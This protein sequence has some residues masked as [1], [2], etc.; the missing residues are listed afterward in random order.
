MLRNAFNVEAGGGAGEYRGG[1]GT[2]REY[3]V[4][5]ESG[6]TLLASLGRSVHA[7]WGVDGGHAGTRQLLRNRAGG[8]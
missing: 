8:R 7:P 3:R 6:G 2:I 4:E 1:F 5:N